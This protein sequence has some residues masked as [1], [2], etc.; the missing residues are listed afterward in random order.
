MFWLTNFEYILKSIIILIEISNK[1]FTI[2]I[3]Y[4]Y[5]CRIIIFISFH[6]FKVRIFVS[7]TRIPAH[8]VSDLSNLYFVVPVIFLFF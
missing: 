6:N 1:S 4:V 5:F 3:I 7:W 8:T 2:W